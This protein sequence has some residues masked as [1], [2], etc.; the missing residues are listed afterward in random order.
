MENY[1]FFLLPAVFCAL[2]A[3]KI[4]TNVKEDKALKKVIFSF[5]LGL[6]GVS[7]IGILIVIFKIY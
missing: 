5:A 6:F 4:N 7:A 2:F 3:G 1:W